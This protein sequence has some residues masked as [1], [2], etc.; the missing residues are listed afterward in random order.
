MSLTDGD[1][2]LG[3]MRTVRPTDS[4]RSSALQAETDLSLVSLLWHDKQNAAASYSYDRKVGAEVFNLLADCRGE[5]PKAKGEVNPGWL[6]GGG[7]CWIVDEKRTDMIEALTRR[8]TFVGPD[9]V[10]IKYIYKDVYL[11]LEKARLAQRK[12]NG[13]SDKPLSARLLTFQEWYFDLAIRLYG[14]QPLLD[15]KGG[16]VV[17]CDLSGSDYAGNRSTVAGGLSQSPGFWPLMGQ[18]MQEVEAD[19]NAPSTR[20]VER[21]GDGGDRPVKPVDLYEEHKLWEHFIVMPSNPYVLMFRRLRLP[22]SFSRPFV[23]PAICKVK[24]DSSDF[25]DVQTSRGIRC[26]HSHWSQASAVERGS[27]SLEQAAMHEQS[28]RLKE[29]LLETESPSA[30]SN[31]DAAVP[32]DNEVLC[33]AELL[34][35]SVRYD[36]KRVRMEPEFTGKSYSAPGYSKRN[37]S[38]GA[39]DGTPQV[40]IGERLP[41]S[42]T[43]GAPRCDVCDK[44]DEDASP[45]LTKSLTT[46]TSSQTSSGAKGARELP[47]GFEL[48][49][50]CV[51]E[52]L[53]QLLGEDMVGRKEHLSNGRQFVEKLT[54]SFACVP[55]HE[56]AFQNTEC[57]RQGKPPGL[58]QSLDL[59]DRRRQLRAKLSASSRDPPGQPRELQRGRSPIPGNNVF[60]VRRDI[61]QWHSG[62]S[63]ALQ[64]ADRSKYCEPG[65]VIGMCRSSIRN[66]GRSSSSRDT[67]LSTDIIPCSRSAAVKLNTGGFAAIGVSSRN[68]SLEKQFLSETPKRTK[69]KRTQTLSEKGNRH[70][71]SGPRVGDDVALGCNRPFHLG[72]QTGQQNRANTLTNK[73]GI[74]GLREFNDNF[75]NPYDIKGYRAANAT[76]I[77]DTQQDVQVFNGMDTLQHESAGEPFTTTVSS[78]CVRPSVLPGRHPENLGGQNES[79][80]PRQATAAVIMKGRHQDVQAHPS[81][82]DFQNHRSA[83][84]ETAGIAPSYRVRHYSASREPTA[85]GPAQSVS[86]IYTG[87]DELCD[88][89]DGDDA[90]SGPPPTN[91]TLARNIPISITNSAIVNK[92]LLRGELRTTALPLRT[93]A[94]RP[95]L[96]AF[97]SIGR[98]Q[99]NI[100]VRRGRGNGSCWKRGRGRGARGSGRSTI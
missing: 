9:R 19:F 13:C 43:V 77:G 62:N 95:S 97:G 96:E 90:P 58:K 44:V 84:L 74:A 40:R 34:K 46:A 98:G 99:R 37:R 55:R 6:A 50:D 16:K 5:L 65:S 35:T 38:T 82:G 78:N 26:S 32:M 61:L 12:F 83:V 70:L 49:A 15:A 29:A 8:N 92:W 67:R 63:D 42:R 60:K 71:N 23:K 25:S 57:A 88:V 80:T 10:G 72:V 68:A 81:I 27:G 64:K 86:K 33:G 36:T 54:A 30:S 11:S 79:T 91:F 94:G 31:G 47:E 45:G 52:R 20:N 100:Q 53:I 89:I 3:P 24:E 85:G 59:S 73:G 22:H 18:Y 66:V 76:Q 17:Q 1:S 87:D 21:S 69:P 14:D 41:L 28:R 51:A 75:R 56:N 48:L 2:P 93:M 7:G 39:C 4:G